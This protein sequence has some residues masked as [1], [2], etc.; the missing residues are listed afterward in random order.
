MVGARGRN[1]SPGNISEAATLILGFAGSLRVCHGHKAQKGERN[2]CVVK[3]SE[4]TR[5]LGL[6]EMGILMSSD[7]GKALGIKGICPRC[8][9]PFCR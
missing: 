2:Y 7:E 4:I 6:L 1:G 9:G 8:P 3:G 5:P